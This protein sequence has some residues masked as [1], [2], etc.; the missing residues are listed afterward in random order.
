[1]IT[2]LICLVFAVVIL[3]AGMSER[4]VA[5]VAL[6]AAVVALGLAGLPG[7]QPEPVVPP[8]MAPT[9]SWKQFSPR[10]RM[11]GG[12]T[13]GL[14]VLTVALSSEE[15]LIWVSVATWLLAIGGLVAVGL[16]LDGLALADVWRK[17]RTIFARRHRPELASVLV[18]TGVAFAMRFYN[19]E[20]IPPLFHGDEGFMGLFGL[21]IME[22]QRYPFFATSNLW[23]LP[24]L[25]NYL[26]ALSMWIFGANVF[27]LRMLSAI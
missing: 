12:C 5:L 15:R 27:G 24:F 10:A 8:S 2:R 21:D 25:F 3:G 22:G 14:S 16:H 6:G 9:W 18:I 11:I 26:Q 23:G 20:M 4:S 7:G 1:M 19:L 13:V 17:T